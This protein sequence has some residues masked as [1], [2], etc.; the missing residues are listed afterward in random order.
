MNLDHDFF[1]VSKLSENQKKIFTKNGTLFC[2]NSN[3]DLRSDAHQNQII[4]R[5][6]DVDHTQTIGGI[7]S[8]Y[9]GGD[10]SP[11]GFDTPG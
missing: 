2:P 10:I 8:N 3:E 6:A 7:Q 11:P 5:D 1:Q 9:W 4:G